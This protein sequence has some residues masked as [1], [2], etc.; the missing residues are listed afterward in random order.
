VYEINFYRDKN[1][2]EPI[3]D[4]L[5][6]LS[7]KNDKDSRI[8]LN[9]IRDYIKILERF[10]TRVGEP[11]VK[12][13]EGDLWELRPLKNRIFFIIL[14]YDRIILLH[15]FVKTTQ[16][17]PKREIAQAKRNMDDFFERSGDK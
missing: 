7:R 3:K 5:L 15:H 14:N 2:N 8:K 13:V 12:H 17:T 9:K 10:G 1:G 6:E 16:K 4:Y 11:F